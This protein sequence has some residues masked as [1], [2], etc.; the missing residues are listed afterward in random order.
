M[1][2]VFAV[3]LGLGA[4]IIVL[5]LGVV[6]YMSHSL[7]KNIQDSI[8]A[9]LE[10]V[11]DADPSLSYQPF[12]C[13]GVKDIWC[14]SGKVDWGDIVSLERVR[15]GITDIGSKSLRIKLES[16]NMTLSSK[17]F[18]GMLLG[19]MAPG[20][21]FGD[22]L[23]PKDIKCS[24]DSKLET[25]AKAE[26]AGNVENAKNPQNP[27][28]SDISCEAKA[29]NAKYKLYIDTRENFALEP[30]TLESPDSLREVIFGAFEKCSN[31]SEAFLRDSSVLIENISFVMTT[32]NLTQKIIQKLAKSENPSE[33]DSAKYKAQLVQSAQTM[34]NF[35]AYTMML[36]NVAYK[37]K[38]IASFDHITDMIGGVNDGICYTL[39]PIDSAGRAVSL[40]DVLSHSKTI[41]NPDFFTLESKGLDKSN[42]SALES[43]MQN[44]SK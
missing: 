6:F 7:K 28:N 22:I 40:E 33:Q 15:L 35:I 29:N 18:L 25:L 19:V 8:N 26:G 39:S 37:E 32:E 31:D 34:K 30:A 17:S 20:V 2:K 4:V 1:K 5:L 12:K 11:H 23:F 36:G 43:C 9:Q 13:H 27:I 41:I 42:I 21:D 10:R 38:I 24:I 44:A 16:S 3:I 14:E